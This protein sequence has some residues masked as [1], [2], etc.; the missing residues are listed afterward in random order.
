MVQLHAM[1]LRELATAG[2][3]ARRPTVG[4]SQEGMWPFWGWLPQKTFEVDPLHPRQR[5]MLLHRSR[6]CIRAALEEHLNG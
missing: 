5:R 2:R 1:Q 3:S 4:G 6:S